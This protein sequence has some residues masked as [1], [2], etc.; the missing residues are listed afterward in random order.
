MDKVDCDLIAYIIQDA[1]GIDG[2]RAAGDII[3]V[4]E[5]IKTYNIL[6][7]KFL[8]KNSVDF[9][10][11]NSYSLV[12]VFNKRISHDSHDRKKHCHPIFTQ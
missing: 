2:L 7:P 1:V 6:P 12:K 3:I 10:I 9:N 5:E 11:K 4:S 8:N